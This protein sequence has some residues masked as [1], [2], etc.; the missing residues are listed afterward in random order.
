MFKY[1]EQLVYFKM[2]K[3]A[4]LLC[5]EKFKFCTMLEYEKKLKYRE[6]LEYKKKLEYWEVI[7]SE[8]LKFCK[9]F[10]YWK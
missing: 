8:K 7:N 1:W 2:L 10:K 4:E 9:M 6:I 5:C 3:Y